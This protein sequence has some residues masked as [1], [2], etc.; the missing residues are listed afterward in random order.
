M[1]DTD[2]SPIIVDSGIALN[3]FWHRLEISYDLATN[4]WMVRLDKQPFT[5]ISNAGVPHMVGG[6]AIN[7]GAWVKA[8]TSTLARLNLTSWEFSADEF[9][10]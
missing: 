9:N 1:D 8:G 5:R 7:I 4:E 6:A 3:T 10:Y 2:G